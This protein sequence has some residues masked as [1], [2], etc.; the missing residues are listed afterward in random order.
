MRLSEEERRAN[1][2]AF[3]AMGPVQKVEYVFAYYKL[4]LVLVG[5]AL[6]VLISATTRA[7]THKDPVLYL[8]F[9]NVVA[10]KEVEDSLT[11]GYL[12]ARGIDLNRNEIT[13]Y[14][15]LYLSQDASVAEHGYAYASRLKLMAS[16]ENEQ[17]DVVLMDEPAWNIL[18]ASGYLKD[19][20]ADFTGNDSLRSNTVIISDNQV[21]LDL[22]EANSYEAETREEQNALEVTHAASLAGFSGDVPLY[23]AVIANTPRADAATD[24]LTY[25]LG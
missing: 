13:C 15:E 25:V 11:Q 6:V 12:E 22:G 3:R 2:E 18:S 9:T 1:R 24:Y 23:I 14:R 7:L 17:L 5:I 16:I 8:G 4:P 21:E 10:P 20:S 19:L